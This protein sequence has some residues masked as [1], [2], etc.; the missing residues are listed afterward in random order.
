[1]PIRGG[2]APLSLASERINAAARQS[3]RAK[4]QEPFKTHLSHRSG[5]NNPFRMQ[6]YVVAHG[7]LR[8]Q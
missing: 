8:P 4:P 6:L 1:M 2:N 3:T 7:A 5:Q